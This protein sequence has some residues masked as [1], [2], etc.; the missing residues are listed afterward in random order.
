VV[1]GGPVD[2]GRRRG[3]RS[4]ADRS[5]VD[6]QQAAIAAG[7]KRAAPARKRAAVGSSRGINGGVKQR[8]PRVSRGIGG[9]KEE[10]DGGLGLKIFFFCNI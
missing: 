2:G 8:R 1:A 5:A 4:T 6:W 7:K 10:N 3:N 9:R